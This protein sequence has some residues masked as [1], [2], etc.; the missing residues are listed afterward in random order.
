MGICHW[1][2]IELETRK[3]LLE[4]L[5]KQN[6]SHKHL[7]SSHSSNQFFL[8]AL[9]FHDHRTTMKYF[10]QAILLCCFV[11]ALRASSNLST[12]SAKNNNDTRQ[13]SQCT[14]NNYNT[15]S[16]GPNSKKIENMISEVKQQLAE[17]K[18]EI[19]KMKE[20]QTGGQ[21]EKGL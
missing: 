20:N 2:K 10:F 19:T 5:I 3:I 16:A 21:A 18:Q 6:Q 8:V 17:L 9:A 15:F 11:A 4:S 1:L 12:K 14:V 7:K 13:T